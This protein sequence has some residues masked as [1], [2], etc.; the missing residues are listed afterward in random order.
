M[1]MGCAQ[2]DYRIS[3]SLMFIASVSMM[4]YI[5]YLNIQTLS[6]K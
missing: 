5:Y 2:Y 1:S 6:E 4:T 3:M